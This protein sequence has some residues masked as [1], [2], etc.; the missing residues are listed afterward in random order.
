MERRADLIRADR[1]QRVDAKLR[2]SSNDAELKADQLVRDIRA[3]EAQTVWGTEKQEMYNIP[4]NSHIFPGMEFLIGTLSLF[5]FSRVVLSEGIMISSRY[6]HG[7]K[8]VQYCRPG[9]SCPIDL[10]ESHS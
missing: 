9:M 3:E 1:T 6:H 2:A 7:H 10:S 5:I 4:K 8:I